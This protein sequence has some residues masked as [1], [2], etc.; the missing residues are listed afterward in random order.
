V[1]KDS[2]VVIAGFGVT[3]KDSPEFGADDL[4][5]V[6]TKVREMSGGRLRIQGSKTICS[7]DSGGPVYQR[8]GDR[9]VVIG[10]SSTSN[11]RTEAHAVRVSAYMDWIKQEI[12]KYRSEQEI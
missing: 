9:F 5:W 4:R 11:C 2:R 3:E 7:G 6:T 12:R 1:P 10:I 8:S